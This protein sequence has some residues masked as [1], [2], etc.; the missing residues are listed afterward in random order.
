MI[1]AQRL[2]PA[3]PL[4]D[5]RQTPFRVGKKSRADL[6][7]LISQMRNPWAQNHDFKLAA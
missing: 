6:N 5:G 4:N 7:A 1:V 2:A 3:M